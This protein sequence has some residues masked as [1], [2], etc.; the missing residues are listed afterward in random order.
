M[1][2][3]RYKLLSILNISIYGISVCSITA[4]EVELPVEI[5]QL[6]QAICDQPQVHNRQKVLKQATKATEVVDRYVEGYSMLLS[7]LLIFAMFHQIVV[8]VQ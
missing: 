6:E 3:D 8:K 2:R 1:W 4:D 7:D 5:L